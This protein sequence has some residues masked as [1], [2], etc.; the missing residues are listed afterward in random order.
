MDT[1]VFRYR[2]YEDLEVYTYGSAAVVGL[3]MC[4]AVGVL[5]ETADHHAE[6]LGVAMQLSNFLRDVKEDYG[7]GPHL[8][9]A[10]GFRAIRV[11]GERPRSGH[12]YGRAIRGTDEVRNRT[13]PKTLRS[14]RRGDAVHST[15]TTLPGDGRPRIICSDPGPDRGPKLRRIL[16]CGPIPRRSYKLRVAAGLAIREP[17]E[18]LARL[19]DRKEPEIFIPA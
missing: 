6:A 11:H 12:R 3:M 16:P 10:R 17:G 5:D 19:R 8:P 14:R 18:I 15:R 13:R 4:R 7:A 2:T 1:H 9:T